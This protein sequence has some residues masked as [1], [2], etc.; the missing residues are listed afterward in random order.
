MVN[1]DGKRNDR[2]KSRLLK[3]V[4][5]F[6]LQLKKDQVCCKECGMTVNRKSLIPSLRHEGRSGNVLKLQLNLNVLN[7]ISNILQ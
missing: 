3:R 4:S 1:K 6:P 2:R 5:P 7:S